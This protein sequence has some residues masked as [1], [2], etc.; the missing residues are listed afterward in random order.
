MGD[1]LSYTM[2]CNEDFPTSRLL[3][4]YYRQVVF[5]KRSADPFS[6]ETLLENIQNNIPSINPFSRTKRLGLKKK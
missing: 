1:G 3:E 6:R 4:Y 2:N 5:G